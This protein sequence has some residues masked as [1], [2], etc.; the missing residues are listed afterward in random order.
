MKLVRSTIKSK[1][2]FDI[3]DLSPIDHVG[4]CFIP[5]LFACATGDDFI[6]PHHTQ[7]LYDKYAGDKNVVRFEGDHNSPRPDFFHNSVVIFFHNTLQIEMLCREDNK[8]VSSKKI[9]HSQYED[10]DVD[11]FEDGSN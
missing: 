3:N 8:L 7:D 1:A 2:N 5:S 6:L 10:Y 4:E 11:D 9:K